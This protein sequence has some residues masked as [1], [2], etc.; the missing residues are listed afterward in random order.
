MPSRNLTRTWRSGLAAIISFQK[1]A[2]IT[3]PRSTNAFCVAADLKFPASYSGGE[4]SKTRDTEISLLEASGFLHALNLH[5]LH[6]PSPRRDR[7]PP[8]RRGRVASSFALL[9]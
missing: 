6:S 4:R 8:P 3:I 7:P 5:E 2:A 9:R 1:Q